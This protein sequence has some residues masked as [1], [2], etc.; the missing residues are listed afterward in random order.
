MRQYRLFSTKN[1]ETYIRYRH[2]VDS[3]LQRAICEGIVLGVVSVIGGKML[4][5]LNAFIPSST[6][7]RGG[8][9]APECNN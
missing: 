2:M 9:W 6:P 7:F 3:N 8:Y 4:Y 1:F 5:P